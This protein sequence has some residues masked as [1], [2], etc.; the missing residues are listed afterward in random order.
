M[1]YTVL[2]DD[3]TVGTLDSG[4]L[5]GQ[6]AEALIGDLVEVRLHDENGNPVS[7]QGVLKEILEVDQ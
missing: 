2:L 7:V 4:K 6:S 1:I 5:N 3:D